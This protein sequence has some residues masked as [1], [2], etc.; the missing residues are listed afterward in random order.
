MKKRI[1]SSMLL[2]TIISMLTVSGTLSAVFYWQTSFSAQREMREYARIL[3]NTFNIIDHDSLSLADMRLTV[4]A[5]NGVVLY[6]DKQDAA[7]RTSRADR[8]EIQEA[9]ALGEGESRRFSDTLGQETYYYALKAEDGSVIRLA[10]TIS[11]IWGMFLG[12]LPAIVLVIL[13]M[14][15]ISYFLAAALTKRIIRPINT[16]DMEAHLY[17]PYDELAPFVQTISRQRERIERQMADMK[18]R[19][20][21]MTAIVDS[22]N[23][24]LILVNA[25]GG[26][27]SVNKSATAIF[28]I[29]CEVSGR[30]IVEVLRD[31]ALNE[32]MRDALAGN[33]SE[34]DFLRNGSVYRVYFS[35]V[36][37]RGAVILFL[38][39]TE[40]IMAEKLRKEFSANVSHELKTP[41]TTI[42]GNVE[43][44]END[45][46]KEADK[47]QFY[48]KIRDEAARLIALIEDIIMLS[49]LDE[50]NE[51]AMAEEVDMAAA[52]E[53]VVQSLAIKANE[54]NVAIEVA[55]DGTL[56]ANRSQMV[57]LLYNLLDNA[58]KYNKQDGK[59]RI[60]VEKGEKC[61][62]ITISD[63]GIGIPKE[64]QSR[65][66]ERFYRVDSSRSKQTGGT[67]L[68]LAIVKHI[69]AA[70]SGE[71]KLQSAVGEGTTI[72]VTLHSVHRRAF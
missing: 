34:L 2:L 21:T 4:V 6:D 24:G 9:M 40:K 26:I 70:Y 11:S 63:T 19:A 43:M 20:D 37:A 47:K 62:H 55:G 12:A 38:D 13:A 50:G 49:Q 42:Y 69:A 10:K 58:I 68:G 44:L 5:P 30:N 33:R 64:A 18:E 36:A 61:I 23:E 46:V 45:M 14:I 54:R 16:V 51:T 32:H 65:I 29:D 1:F 56:C 28:G 67:G 53:T 66:F 52:A 3:K 71:I 59:V 27:L 22:M 57:E 60:A 35:P 48:Q 41:L 25:K 72:A 39:V 7:L 31:A 8:E 15:A 17:T